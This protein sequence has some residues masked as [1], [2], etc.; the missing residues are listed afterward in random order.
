MNTRYLPT[1]LA[2]LATLLFVAACGGGLPPKA[3]KKELERGWKVVG[4]VTEGGGIPSSAGSF[5]VK[6]N[7]YLFKKMEEFYCQQ[8]TP[9]GEYIG[10]GS[11]LKDDK[12]DIGWHTVPMRAKIIWK[13][14]NNRT[15]F[16]SYY[17][18]GKITQTP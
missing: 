18:Q 7:V 13:N 15:V 14:S 1:T 4:Y 12:R 8:Y 3:S 16:W 5:K 9:D 2:L 11:Y 17:C 6:I 10:K